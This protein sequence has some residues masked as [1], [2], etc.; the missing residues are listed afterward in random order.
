MICGALR[1]VLAMATLCF[2][3]PLSFKPLSPTCV[4]YPARGRHTEAVSIHEMLRL[5]CVP[6]I[7]V[8]IFTIRKS[9]DFIVDVGSD[10]GLLHLLV[11][12]GDAAVADVVLDGVIE[13]HRVLG[14]HADVGSKRRL[15]HLRGDRED[16]AIIISQGFGCKHKQQHNKMLLRAGRGY[17]TSFANQVFSNASESLVKCLW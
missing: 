13:E 16:G 7:K 14:D 4:S 11:V 9:H 8:G 6:Q 15:L 5:R 3:P 10:G 12:G 2:S 1:M 17:M